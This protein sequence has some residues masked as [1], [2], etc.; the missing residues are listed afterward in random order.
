MI[1]EIRNT[2]LVMQHWLPLALMKTKSVTIKKEE[3]LCIFE[4]SDEFAQYYHDTVSKMNTFVNKK[5]T[6]EETRMMM[7]ALYEL[8]HMDE[9][10]IH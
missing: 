10:N 6:E 3:V 2:N 1:F 7:E 4:P 5:Q 9:S 8:E